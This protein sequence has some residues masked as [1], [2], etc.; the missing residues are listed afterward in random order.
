MLPNP[1][2]PLIVELFRFFV[3]LVLKVRE[4]SPQN[5]LEFFCF[6]SARTGYPGC[7]TPADHSCQPHTLSVLQSMST[8]RLCFLQTLL[9]SSIY[10]KV[11]QSVPLQAWTSALRPQLNFTEWCQTFEAELCNLDFLPS[12]DVPGLVFVLF[13]HHQR[14]SL[15]SP[16]KWYETSRIV[17]CWFF[18]SGL[19]VDISL[20][21]GHRQ[22]PLLSQGA[23]I[24]ALQ[25]LWPHVMDTGPV[26]K[27]WQI[28]QWNGSSHS[29]LLQEAMLATL[30][31]PQR[32]FPENYQLLFFIS[33]TN[34]W[35]CVFFPL[36]R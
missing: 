21:S 32:Y 24:R 17:R 9:S 10:P 6:Y 28:E 1:L 25:K 8:R 4:L 12:A 30:R 19:L 2:P 11:E 7:W 35:A 16:L 26:Q 23:L 31:K 14:I 5:V 33:Q 22:W 36:I 18:N 20:Q 15:A 3:E 29:R 34:M 27:S 13:S